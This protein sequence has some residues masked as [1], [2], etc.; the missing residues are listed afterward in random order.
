LQ[1]SIWRHVQLLKLQA[2]YAFEATAIRVR[3]LSALSML[4]P[5]LVR[6]AFELLYND[7]CVYFRELLGALIKK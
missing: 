1:Q 4:P 6:R 5:P 3:C 2:V 7:I